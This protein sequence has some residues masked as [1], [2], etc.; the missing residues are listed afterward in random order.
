MFESL[1]DKLSG[2]FDKLTRR[3]ALSEADVGEALREVRR[4]LLEADVALDVARAF[5]EK[6][7]ARAVGADVVKSITPGQMVVKIVHD[8]RVETLGERAEPIVA[9]RPS[10]GRDHDGRPAGR[11]QDDDDRQDRETPQRARE[12]AACSWP[13]STSSALRRRSSSPCS[14]GRSASTRCRSSPARR[15]WRSR[16]RALRAA[17][18]AGL[19]RRAA[20]HGGPH[21]YRRAADGGDGG[22]PRRY[23]RPHEI[24]LVADALTG[25]DAV[26]LAKNFNERVG[27]T[28]IVL[29]RMD[30]DGRGGAALSMRAVTG[31]P[32][33]LIGDRRE[34]GRAGGVPS[35]RARRPHPRHGRHRRLVEKAAAAIDRAGGQDAPSDAQRYVRP[36]ATSPISSPRSRRSAASAAS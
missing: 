22:D 31:K 21:P 24:L 12:E 6:A 16:S 14:G 23:A 2:I 28:G 10:A 35:P 32:I 34:D 36:R 33:K 11:R 5:S 19:R 17:R 27:V 29:T 26:N 3:G 8:V 20:R 15:R 4:A 13:R 25:Q 9:Q 7:Q 1:S 30:G 18:D